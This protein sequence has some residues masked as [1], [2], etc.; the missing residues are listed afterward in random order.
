MKRILLIFA[1]FSCFIGF[2]SAQEAESYEVVSRLLA[3]TKPG[4]PQIIDDSIIFTYTSNCRRAGISFAHE[5]FSNVHW[6]RQLLVPQDPLN[7][8]IPQNKKAPELFKDSG[9]LF[10]VHKIPEDLQE[11]EYRLVI[12]GLWTIDPVNPAS[13]RNSSGLECSVLS[14]PQRQYRPDILKGP[15]GTLAFSFKAEPGEKITVAGNFNG[16]DPFMYELRELSP[17]FYSLTLPLPRGTFQ[18]VFYHRGEP[19]PDPANPRHR[20]SRDGMTVSEAEIP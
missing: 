2:I 13:R 3:M 18:Y 14:L 10:Y 15:F 1:F 11:L 19:V 5:G 20:Y 6:L 7:V 4:T 9:I 8:S 17:G 16:W 12:D